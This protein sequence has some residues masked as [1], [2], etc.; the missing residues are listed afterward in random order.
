MTTGAHDSV[1]MGLT[2][3]AG[4]LVV[5]M[6]GVPA[7]VIAAAV[8]AC[9]IGAPFAKPAGGRRRA[10]AMFGASVVVTCHT[11]SWLALAAMHWLPWLAAH[12]TRTQAG[13]AVLVGIGLH[14]AVSHAP[15]IFANVLARFFKATTT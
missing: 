11:S 6:L 12:E 15:T 9:I 5:E 3:A 2:V 7:S 13:A 1:V 14:I 4:S 8:G 10:A